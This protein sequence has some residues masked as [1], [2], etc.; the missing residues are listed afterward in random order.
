MRLIAFSIRSRIE[1][2]GLELHDRDSLKSIEVSAEDWLKG[3]NDFQPSKN[4]S[5]WMTL[6][7]DLKRFL[8]AN[9]NKR[10]E[11]QSAFHAENFRIPVQDILKRF[12][13][14]VLLR[15]SDIGRKSIGLNARFQKFQLTVLL[16][17][18]SFSENIMRMS[19]EKLQ[20]M[21]VDKKGS[22]ENVV[23]QSYVID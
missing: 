15:I 2:M 10:E 1:D 4:S 9:P 8:L 13:R 6:V 17:K 12:M 7:G 11:L 20:N 18:L 16:I 3:K 21:Q 14:L 19:L 5:S 23:Y 22:N